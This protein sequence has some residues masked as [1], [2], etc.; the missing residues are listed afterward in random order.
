MTD[1]EKF[2][3]YSINN[4]M[5]FEARSFYRRFFNENA[6]MIPL[7]SQKMI[8]DTIDVNVRSYH[9]MTYPSRELEFKFEVIDPITWKKSSTG[10]FALSI[11]RRWESIK[12]YEKL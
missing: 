1:K 7:G 10:Y 4:D 9:D 12:A 11:I 5:G 3:H 6:F 2:I 8:V